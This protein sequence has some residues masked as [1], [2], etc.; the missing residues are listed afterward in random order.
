[1][2]AATASPPF[3]ELKSGVSIDWSAH[4]LE[5]IGR[6]Q[7]YGETRR[8]SF[9][10]GDQK[11]LMIGG[12]FKG[13]VG[14]KDLVNHPG[15]IV[16][17]IP[18]LLDE[19]RNALNSMR[20]S[21]GLPKVKFTQ[22]NASFAYDV[23]PVMEE[24]TSYYNC[25]FISSQDLPFAIAN[26]CHL[27]D[28][29]AECLEGKKVHARG[30]QFIWVFNDKEV[31]KEF[32]LMCIILTTGASSYYTDLHKRARNIYQRRVREA[33]ELPGRKGKLGI[34]ANDDGVFVVAFMSTRRNVVLPYF[35]V[36]GRVLPDKKDDRHTCHALVDSDF[37]IALAD[38]GYNRQ[39]NAGGPKK[40]TK[41][42]KGPGTYIRAVHSKTCVMVAEAMK[43]G[44][45][46]ER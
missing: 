16:Q 37:S 36:I 46:L 5:R 11:N 15:V 28:Q 8:L 41:K 38:H 7:W 45:P 2:L 21:Q 27:C 17:P 10:L 42:G 14:T 3:T 24:T 26:E 43:K 19:A 30:S 44:V 31:S 20:K 35:Y 25:R 4:N 33:R 40:K 1:M 6:V 34:E 18:G 13:F 12:S 22:S 29:V 9:P 32:L 23:V 39:Q